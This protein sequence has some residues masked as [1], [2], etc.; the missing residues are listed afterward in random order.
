MA[1]ASLSWQGELAYPASGSDQLA[2]Y[3]ALSAN[4]PSSALGF[5]WLGADSYTTQYVYRSSTSYGV[6]TPPQP[7]TS[8]QWAFGKP[9]NLAGWEDCMELDGTQ[10]GSANDLRC[11]D[12][13]TA[14]IVERR[15]ASPVTTTTQLPS[16]SSTASETLT[17]TT[18][19]QSTTSEATER[20]RA[21]PRN[22][23]PLQRLGRSR[24][25]LL[26]DFDI[27]YPHDLFQDAEHHHDQINDIGN[28]KHD[29]S[30]ASTN[31]QYR[32]L[33]H[34]LDNEE[35][36]CC[37]DIVGDFLQN[38]SVAEI[39]TPEYDSFTLFR[40]PSFPSVTTTDPTTSGPPRITIQT[41]TSTSLLIA[42][43]ILAMESSTTLIGSS[44]IGSGAS[45]I[46][47]TE[48]PTMSAVVSPA[49]TAIPLVSATV[50]TTVAIRDAPSTFTRLEEFSTMSTVVGGSAPLTTFYS[51]VPSSPVG[52]IPTTTVTS[53]MVVPSERNIDSSNS[54]SS[55]TGTSAAV[56]AGAAV[57]AVAGT[58][59]IVGFA[60]VAVNA[61][62]FGGVST[63]FAA[64]A[65]SAAAGA[66]TGVAAGAG[67]GG[68]AGGAGAGS[69]SAAA[70]G[71]ETTPLLA[72]ATQSA[73][74]SL[75]AV[76]AG[77]AAIGATTGAS[78][79]AST[80]A[81]VSGAATTAATAATT[82]G[83]VL[84]AGASTGAGAV[85]ASTAAVGG[86][87]TASG[88]TAGLQGAGTL[89]N[90][91][92]SGLAGAGTGANAGAG[93][94]LGTWGN[95]GALSGSGTG[96]NTGPLSGT[97]TGA[98]T[99]PVSGAGTGANTVGPVSGGGIGANVSTGMGST[100]GSTAAHTSVMATASAG[101]GAGGAGDGLNL[102]QVIL[103][104]WAA[105]QGGA[106]TGATVMEAGKAPGGSGG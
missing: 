8:F 9:D 86:G 1:D 15:L 96:A 33:K 106:A 29:Y 45:R 49:I 76:S 97:G 51:V 23:S 14:Y 67:V 93:T 57:G 89:A 35:L 18:T 73:P 42:G 44:G 20:L 55:L 95:T 81:F 100:A 10:N 4:V 59:V 98:N 21:P 22:L 85:G 79:L 53:T 52:I 11:F 69:S 66:G 80:G 70:G 32:E 19:T 103:G 6:S 39:L 77:D 25:Q 47:I 12:S 62:L 28:A 65:A 94:G 61:G 84:G 48:V 83:A 91:Q 90:V 13:G 30:N 54:T 101:G 16:T 37:Q 40:A 31:N 27:K 56:I 64:S 50:V 72:V 41:A 36:Y 38:E 63:F 99:G 78:F 74:L 5:V 24:S 87:T 46:P 60:V 7:L 17:T 2:M 58:V 71:T 92:A 43:R 102:A 75:I 3:N 105:G 104:V 82:G 34:D 68:A 88:A 26:G